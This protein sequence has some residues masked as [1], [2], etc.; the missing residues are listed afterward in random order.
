M[1]FIVNP[2][3]SVKTLGLENNFDI[4]PLPT[5]FHGPVSLFG[6]FDKY[7]YQLF[8]D[9]IK[10]HDWIIQRDFIPY[11]LLIALFGDH[12]TTSWPPENAFNKFLWAIDE[13]SR[14]PFFL[15]IHLFPTHDPY[16]PSKPF[17]GMFDPSSELRSYKSQ[18]DVK[19][20]ALKYR[21]TFQDFPTEVQ[22]V[23]NTLR[24]RY[25]EFI[26]Y[27]DKHFED[28]VQQLQERDKLKNT[29]IILSSD[30]G[31]SFE[32]GAIQHSGLH[33]YEQVTHIPLIIKEPHQAN[34]RI[35]NDVVEQIDIPA[36]ILELANIPV[37][38][39]MEGR[40]LVPLMRGEDLPAKPALSMSLE[41]NMSGGQEITKGTIAVWEGDHKLIH[42]LDYN[43]SLLFNLKLD[44]QELD[45]L[46]DKEPEKGQHLLSLIRENLDKANRNLR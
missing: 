35:I 6:H 42:Y 16:L 40:S 44:P 11:R 15:W 14:E 18:L 32:H 23:I 26:R 1:A 3:A 24:N 17:I 34:G 4:A 33:L 19:N 39:W 9:K 41:N 21:D 2:Y 12:F 8:G 27:C 20:T 46:W 36:T 30:H 38:I 13:R 22:P 5:Q 25:D 28:F 45:N 29:I 43:R 10:L 37:P 7:L 31:E